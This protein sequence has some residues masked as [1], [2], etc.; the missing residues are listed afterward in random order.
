MEDLNELTCSMNYEAEYNRLMDEHKKLCDK[1][2][3][4]QRELAQSEQEMS[5]Q[6]GFQYAVE[7]IFGNTK[8]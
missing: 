4:L 5:W 8:A 2:H 6:K 7:L 3:T 1:V